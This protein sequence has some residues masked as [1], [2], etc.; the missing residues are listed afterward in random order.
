MEAVF[1]KVLNM[2][3]AASWL[4]L[5][6]AAFRLLFR[7]APKRV[8]CA[9]WVLVGI[10]LALPVTVKSVLS[11][12]PS[13]ETV[14]AEILTAGAPALSTGFAVVNA[15]INPAVAQS[16]AADPG[17][18]VNKAQ[19]LA[20]VCAAVWLAGIAAMLIYAAVSTLRVRRKV[21]EAVP[22]EPGVF[23]CGGIPS[24][25]ILGI[26]RPKIYLPEAIDPA[27]EA[28]VLAHE[29]AHLRR[30]DH[31]WKPLGFLLLSVHWFNPL[32]W[33]AYILLCRDIEFACDE[34][35]IRELGE[36]GKKPYSAA[37]IR[38]AMPR[39]T[40][41][42]CP[43]A[44]G[45]VGVKARIRS[46]LSYR[47]PAFWI[48]L[49]A[50]LALTVMAVVLLTDPVGK[51]G[52]TVVPDPW[53]GTVVGDL[54][55]DG[56]WAEAAGAVPASV[57]IRY[58]GDWPG[59]P[60]ASAGDGAVTPLNA[61]RFAV[62]NGTLRYGVRDG[63]LWE[64]CAEL[65]P[66]SLRKSNFDALFG[67]SF[68]WTDGVSAEAIRTDC[69]AA[70][71]AEEKIGG[72]RM[73]LTLVRRTDGSLL[74]CR[75]A[76][77]APNG[78]LQVCLVQQLETGD[79]SREART[80]RVE[81]QTVCVLDNMEC[82]VDSVPPEDLRDLQ[83]T[84]EGLFAVSAVHY[85]PMYRVTSTAELARVR[86]AFVGTGES[87]HGRPSFDEAAAAYD[88]AFF[89]DRMLFVV[90]A[91]NFDCMLHSVCDRN[92]TLAV[93]LEAVE[94]NWQ[95]REYTED[96]SFFLVMAAVPKE[97]G[98]YASY[99]A[100]IENPQRYRDKFPGYFDPEDAGWL[101]V[102]A[103]IFGWDGRNAETAVCRYGLTVR[104]DEELELSEVL[105]MPLASA[106]EMR[107]ILAMHHLSDQRIRVIPAGHPL[108]SHAWRQ[109][110]RV[111][112]PALRRQL[113]LEEK[114]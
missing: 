77:L 55:Y 25:F 88:E 30:R 87:W 41:A 39:R 111:D 42:A 93:H 26:L 82:I 112:D 84:Q 114:H 51:R 45:E 54:G 22:K 57:G 2:S 14:P 68:V 46:V 92:G 106:R 96:G 43:L 79:G 64:D 35:V 104:S 44:F 5:A 27:D 10:R 31:L 98:A 85:L 28:C 100:D 47:R 90:R 38:C 113:G 21:R 95:D 1:L 13:G 69:A 91:V 7:R 67:E 34:K 107:A 105:R 20:A 71:R 86:A 62:E 48:I 36:T 99:E 101:D 4:V 37:L 61:V 59:F 70:A 97:A 19:V 49:A 81:A 63:S 80:L 29:R 18:S 23:V 89:E 12:I 24:P 75:A 9:A 8:V 74:L 16:L 60:F 32:M 94:E 40:V 6:V 110:I 17:D 72:V 78:P 73:V 103:F 108:S 33:L 56:A 53:Q 66:V 109:E 50:V 58:D 3:I 11:L 65:K 83:L 102:Y 15:A 76:N 52:Q